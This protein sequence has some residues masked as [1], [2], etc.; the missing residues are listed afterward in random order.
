[1]VHVHDHMDKYLRQDQFTPLQR[2][3]IRAGELALSALMAALVTQKFIKDLFPSA[4]PLCWV[5]HLDIAWQR[6]ITID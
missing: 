4:W 1:M 6:N 2:V 3:N 5:S